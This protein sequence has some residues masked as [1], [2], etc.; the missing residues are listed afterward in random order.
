MSTV[1]FNTKDHPFFD[2]LKKKVD[3]Y[4]QTTGK[5]RTGDWS[6]F[7]KTGILLASL[8]VLYFLLV[9]VQLPVWLSLVLCVLLGLTLAGIGFNVMHDSAHGSFSST[10]WINQIFGYSLN[11]M[12]GDVDLWKTKHNL[13][14]HSFTNIE[15]Y[16]D[17]IDIQPMMRL[18]EHQKLY[19]IHKYQHIYGF[20]LYMINYVLWVFY[21][22]FKKYF[23]RK[24]GET[25]IRK[26][27]TSQH[28]VFWVT[29]A[30]YFMV[31]L[32]VPIAMLGVG[33]A[34]LGYFIVTSV[35]GLVIG[36]VFQLAHV[37][38]G[39]SFVQLDT[40]K[41]VEEE[42]A[43]HQIK[44]TSDFAMSS[45]WV[46]WFVGGLNFQVEHHLFPRISHVHYPE[47]SKLVQQTC[48]EF[49]IKYNSHKTVIEAVRSHIDHLRML[50]SNVSRG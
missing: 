41:K 30:I 36:V 32:I 3:Q 17:D 7:L 34:L 19:K 38:E 9:F 48:K 26:Y 27:S 18:N 16:D 12:G 28:I 21:F 43:V 44:T 20:F 37:V 14:H 11:V 46:H 31:F 22:D 42:W 29:K 13:I 1:Q 49:N 23:S 47:I 33:K 35:T 15:G 2:S 24:I 25:K 50:G 39:A 6:I 5:N 45:K 10:P 40:T 4:F 8:P